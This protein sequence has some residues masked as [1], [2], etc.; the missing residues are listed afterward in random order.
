MKMTLS[1]KWSSTIGTDEKLAYFIEHEN[2][3][4]SENDNGTAETFVSALP[5]S[6]SDLDL[7]ADLF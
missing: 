7:T 3:S 4:R 1:K 2:R 6:F 5:L